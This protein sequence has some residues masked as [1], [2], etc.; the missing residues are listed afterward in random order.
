MNKKR[1]SWADRALKAFI[2]ATGSDREDAVCDLLADICH[3]CDKEGDIYFFNE[4]KRA[5]GH[6]QEET[7]GAGVQMPRHIFRESF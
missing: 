3:W 6:Y 5:I 4:L 1:A 7:N 2:K